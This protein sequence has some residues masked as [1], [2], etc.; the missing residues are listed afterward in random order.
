MLGLDKIL[1]ALP[2]CL[3]GEDFFVLRTGFISFGV[4]LC[5]FKK[6]IRLFESLYFYIDE[7]ENYLKCW[8]WH[9]MVSGVS[10]GHF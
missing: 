2:D 1:S 7:I 6:S 8:G 3:I 10:E 9:G 4:I 5:F